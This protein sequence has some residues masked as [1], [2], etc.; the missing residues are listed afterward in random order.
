MSFTHTIPDRDGAARADGTH[1]RGRSVR[2]VHV[3]VV[4]DDDGARA[5]LERL[6]RQ[7]GF[8]TSTA[9]GGEAALAEAGRAIPDVVLTDLQMEPMHG[10]EV[11]RRLHELDRDLPVIVMTGYSD[12]QSVIE[13]LRAGADDYLIKP[14]Q[15]D[16]VIW[17]VERALARRA[18]KLEHERLHRTV[19]ERLLLSSIREQEHAEA[20]ARRRTELDALLRNLSE[21]VV[22]GDQ[23]G[24][25]VML[26]DAARAILG[27]RGDEVTVMEAELPEACDLEGRPLSRE[28]RPL[29]RA[30][31]GEQFTDYEVLRTRPNGERR[32]VASTGTNVRDADGNVA[33]AIVVFRDI[34]EM[35]RLEEQRDEYLALV[36]HDLRNPLTSILMCLATLKRYLASTGL[37]EGAELPG[38][39]RNAQLVDRAER[40]VKR[41]AAMLEELNEAT[42]LES[43]GIPLRRVA[44]DLR[45]LVAGVVDG[46]ED[47]RARR[48]TIETDDGSPHV[49]LADAQRLERVVANLITNALKYSADDAPVTVRLGYAGSHV[50]I[51]VVDRGI[52]I[53][54]ESVR[55]LFDRYYRTTGGKERASGLG[56]G[57]Y[58]ARL[59]AEAHGGR[60]EVSS[61]IGK[62]SAFRLILP[63]FVMAV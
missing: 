51:E 32:R 4:E 31:R 1:E 6:L 16:A 49:V 36:S 13:C 10:V 15:Y 56:L 17:C 53:P 60:I 48:I 41:M 50:Q 21:G 18:E 11:C 61:E 26:N 12:M 25:I 20:E 33:M 27:I 40:N 46:M 35:R 2:R 37:F 62:G 7:E 14:L 59:I 38:R 28:Q 9:S 47:A 58:I 63:S 3:L 55:M 44:C 24:R 39:T 5:A 19:H 57:L 42:S 34:T 43:R 8:A 30:L 45:E 54:P 29:M 23:L 22:I 52:G